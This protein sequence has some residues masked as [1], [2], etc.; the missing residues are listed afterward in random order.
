MLNQV[1]DLVGNSG[2][3]VNKAHMYD[4]LIE[5][6]EPSLARQTLQILIKYSRTMMD[7]LK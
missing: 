6:E 1:Q 2:G 4:K 7:L 5:A 3:V